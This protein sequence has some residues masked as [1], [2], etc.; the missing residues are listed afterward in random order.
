MLKECLRATIDTFLP[1]LCFACEQKINEGYLCSR[2]KEKIEF[3]YPPLCPFCSS[4]VADNKTGLC[5]MCLGKKY[6]YDRIICVASYK[7]PMI[8]FIRL[9]KY[10]NCDYLEKFLSTLMIQ[11]LVTIGFGCSSFDVISA[12]PLH[13]LKLKEREYNQAAL[14]GK[15]LSKYFKIPFRDD[16]IYEYKNKPSQTALTKEARALNVKGAFRVKG[17]LTNKKVILID[18]IFTTGSTMQECSQG[19]RA[20]GTN[21]IVGI[22]LCKAQ[23]Q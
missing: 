7:E 20:H 8:S 10:D 13:P 21:T 16:I 1:T 4:P 9:F 12:I 19:L 11:H 17:E 22:T 14:L 5:K 15:S 18:D 23:V 3:L 2:C 6:S